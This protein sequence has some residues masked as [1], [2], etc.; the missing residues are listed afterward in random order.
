MAVFNDDMV[1]NHIMR[2]NLP[3]QEKSTLRKWFDTVSGGKTSHFISKYGLDKQIANKVTVSDVIV[4]GTEALGVGSA[5][6]A[7]HALHGLDV[8]VPMTASRVP[9]DGALSG[10]SYLGAIAIPAL[11]EHLKNIGT[12]AAA[13]YGFRKFNDMLSAKRNTSSIAGEPVFSEV[14]S[15]EEASKSDIGEDPIITLAKNLDS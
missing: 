10:L 3:R 2:S 15:D 6:G 11:G 7:L 8:Q 12:S 14:A 4:A 1:F 13:V 5:L 9:V